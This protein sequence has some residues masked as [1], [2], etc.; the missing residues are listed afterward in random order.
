MLTQFAVA[1]APCER[2]LRND[3]REKIHKEWERGVEGKKGKE[4]YNCHRFP[5]S[6]KARFLNL[7][8][9]TY[10][11]SRF[12]SKRGESQKKISL[13]DLTDRI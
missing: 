10:P 8:S 4:K 1:V 7:N 2:A 3:M 6:N 12:C 11:I 9:K 5:C 13:L